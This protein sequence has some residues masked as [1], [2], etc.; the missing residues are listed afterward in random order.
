MLSGRLLSQEFNL[1]LCSF[2]YLRSPESILP[3]QLGFSFLELFLSPQLLFPFHS[4][5]VLPLRG[6]VFTSR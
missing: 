4:H 5:L 6:S 2:V 3:K 1:T